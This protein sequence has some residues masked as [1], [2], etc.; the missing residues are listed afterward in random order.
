MANQVAERGCPRGEVWGNKRGVFA[1]WLKVFCHRADPDPREDLPA[2]PWHTLAWASSRSRPCSPPHVGLPPCLEPPYFRKASCHDSLLP[3]V[4]S[5]MRK[6]R[7]WPVDPPSKRHHGS[8]NRRRRSAVALQNLRWFFRS[9]LANTPAVRAFRAGLHCDRTSSSQSGLCLCQNRSKTGR[10]AGQW[11]PKPTGIGG[12]GPLPPLRPAMTRSRQSR[13]E[14]N[15]CGHRGNRRCPGT[16][17]PSQP[18]PGEWD[19]RLPR[20]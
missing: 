7:I 18:L 14:C 5:P 12:R 15:R 17:E 1:P 16:E 2:F 10:W 8:T 19:W 9:Q 6:Q 3:L 13:G 11:P 4:L 20:H